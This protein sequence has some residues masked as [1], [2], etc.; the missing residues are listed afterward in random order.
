LRPIPTFENV[1]APHKELACTRQP[2]HDQPSAAIH[3]ERA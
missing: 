3:K 2:N 1:M